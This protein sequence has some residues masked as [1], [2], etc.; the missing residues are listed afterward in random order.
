[1]SAHVHPGLFRKL[2]ASKLSWAVIALLLLYTLGGFL[3]APWLVERYLPRYADEQLGR[4]AT[5][6]QVRINPF[7]LTLAADRF[8]LEGAG[9]E[10]TLAF[11]SLF[12]DFELSSLF[13]D[14]WTFALVRLKSPSVALRIDRE[15]RFNLAELMARLRDPNAPESEP[16]AL[17]FQHVVIE[18]GRVSLVDLSG[19]DR[20]SVV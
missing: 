19:R 16:P 2:A 9:E 10:A 13:A 14:A 18:D 7:L 4:R 6:E 5:I 17:M 3:L 1:M 11:E 12:V 15:G 8:R 20:K